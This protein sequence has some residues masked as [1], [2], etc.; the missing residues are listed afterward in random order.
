MLTYVTFRLKEKLLAL[1]I[2]VV[3]VILA[4]GG[5]GEDKKSKMN[6]LGNA[7]FNPAG[8]RGRLHFFGMGWLHIL[9]VAFAVWYL[10]VLGFHWKA[11]FYNAD[12]PEAYRIPWWRCDIGYVVPVIL[13]FYLTFVNT[14]KRLHDAH[15]SNW[16]FPLGLVP[17]L[18]LLLLLPGTKGEN[19][20]GEQP[21]TEKKRG[22]TQERMSLS[23]S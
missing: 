3:L 6:D 14:S 8:R 13:W 22:E 19:K 21:G 17:L 15:L 18:N 7:L 12:L 11:R 10:G 16:L 4:R 5:F 1:I 2:A 20:Y 9:I 23:N